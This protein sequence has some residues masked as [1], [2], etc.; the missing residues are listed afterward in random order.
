[1]YYLLNFLPLLSLIVLQVFATQS[2]ITFP[3]WFDVIYVI[4]LMFLLPIYL[5]LVNKVYLYAKKISYF[6]SVFS[7][8]LAVIANVIFILVESK[9][10]TGYW[11]DSKLESLYYL[12]VIFPMIIIFIGVFLLYALQKE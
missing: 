4:W 8:S 11:V 7:M 3:F 6:K 1:M 2:D 12:F 5:L 9:I 10:T